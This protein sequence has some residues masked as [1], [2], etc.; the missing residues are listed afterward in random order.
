MKPVPALKL[1]EAVAVVTDVVEV[2]VAAAEAVAEV[3]VE[4][5]GREDIKIKIS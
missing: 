3:E 2:E 4:A 1:V 5:V